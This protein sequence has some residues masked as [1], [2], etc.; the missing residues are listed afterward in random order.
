MIDDL[1]K[2]G[3]FKLM[4]SYPVDQEHFRRSWDLVHLSKEEINKLEEEEFNKGLEKQ[5][6]TMEAGIGPQAKA[7][8][9]PK[10]DSGQVSQKGT[11]AAQAGPSTNDPRVQVRDKQSSKG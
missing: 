9:E 4:K 6:A 1:A 3:Q 10:E 11:Q 8:E 7:K 2:A 5:K